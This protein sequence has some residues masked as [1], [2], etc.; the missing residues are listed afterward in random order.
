MALLDANVLMYAVGA[1][2]PLRPSSQALL[3]RLVTDPHSIAL[4]AEVLQE[5][6]HRYR[7]LRRWDLVEGVFEVAGQLVETVFPITQ[8]TLAIARQVMER[9]QNASARDAIHCAVVWEHALD[10][11]C[12]FDRDFDSFEDLDRFTPD[13]TGQLIK[14]S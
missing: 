12:S 7:S 2:H 4:D 14:V 6:L 10:G 5:I 9:H 11:I 3:D 1:E 13:P 8:E